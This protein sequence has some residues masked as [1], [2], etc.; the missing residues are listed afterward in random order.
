MRFAA[1]LLLLWASWPA[2]A[3]G[4]TQESARFQE[5]PVRKGDTLWG[6]ANIYLKDPS[7]W[8]EIIKYNRL[9]SSDP[10]VALPGMTLKIPLHLIKEQLRAAHLIYKLNQVSFR[11]QETASWRPAL[12]KM[13]LYRGDS[14]RTLAAS[15]AKVKFINADLL[16]LDSDSLAIIKPINRDYDVELKNGGVFAGRSRVVTASARITPKTKDTQYSAKI[17]PDLTTLVEV[18]TGM[19]AVEGQGRTVDV[20]AGMSSEVRL[21]LAPSVPIKIADLPQFE[22]RAADFNGSSVAGS[23]RLKVDAK[24]QL[25]FGADAD[26]INGAVDAEKLK[27]EVADLSVGLPISGYRVQASRTRDF[28]R[29][30]YDKVFEPEEKI[31]LKNA[32]LPAG[33]YWWRVALIDLLGTEGKFAAPRLYSVG[34]ASRG[35]AVDLKSSLLL[36]K[37]ASDQ[38]AGTADYR[39][40]GMVKNNDLSVMVNGKTA[41]RDEKG[42]FFLDIRLQ[43]GSNDI[44]VVV[45]DSAGNQNTVTRRVTFRP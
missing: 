6:I 34:L 19:A 42:N 18:Y 1:G 21:G 32:G 10:A 11:R 41:R 8:D 14:L 39:V 45:S 13:E 9:P 29:I 28:D 5:V 31:N 22:A 3:P 30:A 43:A 36:F 27:G 44:V 26:E 12:E 20:K 7:K 4:W 23:A 38:I 16:N 2:P 17:G 25:P 37:P 40:A 35:A 24:A 33:V 15:R